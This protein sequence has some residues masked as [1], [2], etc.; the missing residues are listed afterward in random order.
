VLST[1]FAELKGVVDKRFLL[2]SF[3]PV[4]VAAFGIDLLAASGTGGITEQAETWSS[5]PGLLQALIIGGGLA[6]ILVIAAVLSSSSLLITQLYE[7]YFGPKFLKDWWVE[8]QAQRKSKSTGNTELRFPAT[9][10]Q[11]TALGN[12]LRAAEEY[13]KRAYGLTTVVVWPRLFLVLPPDVLL[14]MQGPADT[15]QFLLNVSLIASAFAVLGG[16]YAAIE[17]L[18]ALAYLGLVVGGLIVARLT[19]L[20]AVEAAIDYGLHIKGA[21]DLHRTDLLAELHRA[22]PTTSDAELRLWKDV[23]TRLQI[24]EPMPVR[25]VTPPAK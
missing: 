15:I 7:G 25:Y 1:I 2:S 3:F 10:L 19:Y 8:S 22:L 9:T 23:S 11:P 13:P 12:V 5:Y 21:F 20:G 4:L 17:A 6:A 18:G 24:G 16:I 14:S